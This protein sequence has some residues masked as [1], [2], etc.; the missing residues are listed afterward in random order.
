MDYGDILIVPLGYILECEQKYAE[1][2]SRLRSFKLEEFTH[3]P[4]YLQIIEKKRSLRQM[5]IHFLTKYKKRVVEAKIVDF[6]NN[7]FTVRLLDDYF[8]HRRRRPGNVKPMQTRNR[9]Y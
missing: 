1:I 3:F 2:P 8:H 5:R 7:K 9:K 6:C 4:N